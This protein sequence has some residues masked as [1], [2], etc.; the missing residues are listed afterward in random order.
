[1]KRPAAA[2]LGLLAVLPGVSSFAPALGN[3]LVSNTKCC[4]SATSLSGTIRFVGDAS[5]RLSTPS[6]ALSELD[7]DKSLSEFLTSDASD[8]VLLGA[9]KTGKGIS[10]CRQMLDDEGSG[11]SGVRWECRQASVEWF[12]M[13][14]TPIFVNVIDKE[15]DKVVISIVDAQT[16]IQQGGRI[17]KTFAS[18]MKRSIFEGRNVVAWKEDS[19]PSNTNGETIYSLEGNLELKLAI[20]L[21]PFLP[22]PPGFNTIGGKIISRT[23]RDRL[24]QNLSDISDAYLVWAT[25]PE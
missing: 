7:G 10:E 3:S 14:L 17:G 6:I 22:L 24:R 11:G 12:G 9:K 4:R 21:P 1:M 19:S 23:C 16:D 18:A 20:S 13:Q 8:S 5:A 2:L 15:S 25:T